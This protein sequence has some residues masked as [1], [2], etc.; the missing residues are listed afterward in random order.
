MTQELTEDLD[1]DGVTLPKGLPV[2]IP[3][4]A[5]HSHPEFWPDA[6]KFDPDR[7]EGDIRRHPYSYIPF[8][9]GPRNCIGQKFA[10][11]EEKILVASVLRYFD[12]TTKQM[13]PPSIPEA[14]LRP[15]DGIIVSLTERKH[16]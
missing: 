10:Q 11:I 14:I 2:V 7:W 4:L 3:I 13:N 16:I 5:L 6:E 15:A 1:V 12:V 9:A 8:S